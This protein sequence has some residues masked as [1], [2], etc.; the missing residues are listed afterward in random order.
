MRTSGAEVTGT[1]YNRD[2]GV[3]LG[4]VKA[5]RASRA[6]LLSSVWVVEPDQALQSAAGSVSAV[7]SGIANSTTDRVP[8]SRR[9]CTS[10]AYVT[11]RAL[12]KLPVSCIRY[13]STVLR[14]AKSGGVAH[15]A[16]HQSVRRRGVATMYVVRCRTGTANTSNRL[17]RYD[18]SKR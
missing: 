2:S 9:H 5:G 16:R 1:A 6:A 13:T 4:T 10:S 11:P 14:S 3:T 8:W 15:N 18:T 17:E 7:R 12:S